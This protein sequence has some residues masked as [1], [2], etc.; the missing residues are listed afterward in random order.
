MP[1]AEL[2]AWVVVPPAD[3]SERSAGCLSR[4]LHCVLSF[5]ELE[6]ALGDPAVHAD[7]ARAR[8]VGRRYAEL[9]PIIKALDEYARLTDDLE[10]GLTCGG[11]LVGRRG[12]RAGR[13][14][15]VTERLTRLLAPRDPRLLGCADG[16]QVR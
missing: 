10:A 8:K 7:L 6:T 14:G 16:D 5:Q 3:K 11:L 1:G 15:Q 4:W 9:T 12:G 13:L 2:S